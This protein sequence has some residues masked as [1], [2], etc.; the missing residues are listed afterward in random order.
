MKAAGTATFSCYPLPSSRPSLQSGDVLRKLVA[1]PL[2]NFS[3][4][5][6]VKTTIR[7]CR[8]HLLD[9]KIKIASD[10]SKN[11][12]L[13]T[14]WVP[15]DKLV[16]MVGYSIRDQVVIRILSAQILF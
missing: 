9:S 7:D 6:A 2:S 15:K 1:F 8:A 14:A 10:L 16:D 3:D 12:L 4:G 5:P 13:H 11:V